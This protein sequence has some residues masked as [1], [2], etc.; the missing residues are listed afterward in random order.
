M[1]E[2]L[3]AIEGKDGGAVDYTPLPLKVLLVP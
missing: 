2:G 1:P 3:G